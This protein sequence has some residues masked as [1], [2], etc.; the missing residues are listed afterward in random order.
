MVE[1]IQILVFLLCTISFALLVGVPVILATPDEW[2]K[3]QRIVW[4]S[5][6]LWGGLII[7]TSIFNTLQS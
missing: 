1:I 6:G 7:L 2:E 3:S 5:S 4:G